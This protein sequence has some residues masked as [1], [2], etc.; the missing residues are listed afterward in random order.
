MQSVGDITMRYAVIDT[1]KKLVVNV[2][3]APA[4]WKVPSGFKLVKSSAANPDDTWDGKKIIDHRPKPETE[5][6]VD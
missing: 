2:I 6:E 3:E 4:G 5:D 1:N